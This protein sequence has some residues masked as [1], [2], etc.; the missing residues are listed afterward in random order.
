[1][2][3]LSVFRYFS[4]GLSSLNLGDLFGSSFHSAGG[5]MLKPI[6]LLRFDA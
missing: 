1:L 4:R 6:A 3:Y 2:L 5:H